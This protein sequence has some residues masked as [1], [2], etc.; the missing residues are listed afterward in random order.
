[1]VKAVRR[2]FDVSDIRAVRIQCGNCGSELV[3]DLASVDPSPVCLR[4]NRH[5]S[6]R[7]ANWSATEQLLSAAQYLLENQD[8]TI[9]FEIDE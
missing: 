7:G 8:F 2:I 3:Q 1:M 9:R 5:L 4:C 6:P